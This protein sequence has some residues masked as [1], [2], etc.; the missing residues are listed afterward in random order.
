MLKKNILAGCAVALV[1]CCSF[2]W[3]RKQNINMVFI[4]DSI[5]HGSGQRDVLPTAPPFYA[6][7]YI[8]KQKKAGLVQFS[9]QGVSGYTTVNFLPATNTVFN[10]VKAAA[11]AFYADK[12]ALLVFSIM[13]GTNDSAISGPKGA[14]VTTADYRANLKTIADSLLLAYPNCKIVF[15]YPIWYSPE[16]QNRGATYL[17]QGQERLR[18]Y[19]PQIDTLVAQYRLTNKG[20]VFSGDTLAF[21]YF[22]QNYL[23]DLKPETSPNGVTFYLHPNAKG[24]QALGEFWGKAIWKAIK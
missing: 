4:G 9:N 12:N 23:S 17:S 16:T 20:H 15:N 7:E 2:Y 10:K 22:K 19:W 6:T 13:L 21:S 11:N 24:N 8:K 18:T 14:P 3:G 5:T 1:L